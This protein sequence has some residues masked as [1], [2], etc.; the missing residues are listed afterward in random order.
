L[1][2]QRSPEGTHRRVALTKR[3]GIGGVELEVHGGGGPVGDNTRRSRGPARQHRGRRRI[4]EPGAAKRVAAQRTSAAD[5]H[6]EGRGVEPLD[7]RNKTRAAHLPRASRRPDKRPE[8][9]AG[10]PSRPRDSAHHRNE[11][12]NLVL[13]P[14]CVKAKFDNTCALQATVARQLRQKMPAGSLKHAIRAIGVNRPE[15]ERQDQ[16]GAGDYQRLLVR[17]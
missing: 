1:I 17:R 12:G 11:Q 4:S 9:Q 13:L 3:I 16:T 8:P 15:T 5:A 10:S 2:G 7:A 14:V 6:F